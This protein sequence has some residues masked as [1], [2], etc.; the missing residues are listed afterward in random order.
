[1]DMRFGLRNVRSMYRASSLMTVLRELLKYKLDLV[2]VQELRW[3][4]GGT[5]HESEYT[6]EKGMRI[7]S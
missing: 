4:G 1:M 5:E 6:S 3:E 7:M 2:W